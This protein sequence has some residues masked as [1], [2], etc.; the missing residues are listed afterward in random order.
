MCKPKHL[1]RKGH[2]EVCV[3]VFVCL[4][5]STFCLYAS[6]FVCF[7]VCAFERLCMCVCLFV[8][9]NVCFLFKLLMFVYLY[10]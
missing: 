3:Y 9:L 4:D 2:L 6:M 8:C 10:I 1:T 7:G 5:R